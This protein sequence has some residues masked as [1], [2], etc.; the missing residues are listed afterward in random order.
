MKSSYTIKTFFSR[1]LP[2]L[3]LMILPVLVNAQVDG[4]FR[5]A[6]TGIWATPA[7]W[8]K[9]T[10]ATSSWAVSASQPSGTAAIVTVRTGHTITLNTNH[11]FRKLTVQSGGSIIADGS[12]RRLDMVAD[13]SF[14]INNGNIGG[15]SGSNEVKLNIA[16]SSTCTIGTIS[17]TG[18]TSI[19]RIRFNKGTSSVPMNSTMIID[20]NMAVTSSGI[21]A[22]YNDG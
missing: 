2:A 21:T 6:A 8:E 10:A 12:E 9:Y 22:Y 16:N 3:V 7:T 4:E 13:T 1:V 11:T 20:M 19:S 14:V 5:S 17:G 18:T 15:V